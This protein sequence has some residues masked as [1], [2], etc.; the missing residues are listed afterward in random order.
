MSDLTHVELL[1]LEKRIENWI[2]FGHAAEEQILDKRRRILSFAPGSILRSCVGRRTT[3]A[4]SSRAS[5]FCGRSRLASAARPC[6]MYG[7]AASSCC[8]CPVGPRSNA[9]CRLS[10]PSRRSASTRPTPRPIIGTTST[11]VCP[12]TKC[13][14][15]TRVRVIRPGCIGGG[16][17]RD[18]PRDAL[19]DAGGRRVVVSTI[20][21]KPVPRYSGTPPVACRSVFTGCT[22]PANLPSPSLS[23]FSRL[24]LSQHSFEH[25]RICL[26]FGLRYPE[27]RSAQS[28]R[29][30][31]GQIFNLP[32]V[33]AGCG[34]RP[35]FSHGISIK[36]RM[37]SMAGRMAR[38]AARMKLK[39]K[40]RKSWH[41]LVL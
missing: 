30:A 6:P 34:K 17:R 1:W 32:S 38:G 4:Q 12:S 40:G 18:W 5:T 21:A 9:C 3:S 13:R 39:H 24:N 37:A 8:G 36:A 15:F 20:A 29:P 35:F 7:P 10:M 14:G 41:E 26:Q 31:L 19:N 27:K 2:R 25:G 11:I 16:S 23:R 33:T 22:P 28:S